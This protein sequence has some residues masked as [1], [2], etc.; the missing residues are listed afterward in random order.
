MLDKQPTLAETFRRVPMQWLGYLDERDKNVVSSVQIKFIYENDWSR[1]EQ[2]L[3]SSWNTDAFWQ[4]RQEL[5]N[6]LKLQNATR[7]EL[8]Y[9][10]TSD[11]AY[12]T[13]EL[14]RR[15]TDVFISYTD[16][17][18]NKNRDYIP[19]YAETEGELEW[20]N[21]NCPHL[22]DPVKYELIPWFRYRT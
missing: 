7:H 3:I 12:F 2:K 8:T 20:V 19:L 10:V 11:R 22:I 5:I 13:D 6:H 9:I 17:R 21:K 18:G 15:S 16:K 4:K 14:G 1:E